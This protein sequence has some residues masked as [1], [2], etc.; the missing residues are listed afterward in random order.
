MKSRRLGFLAVTA[1]FSVGIA[2]FAGCGS[3]S[4][5]A[6]DDSND[7]GM[8]TDVTVSDSSPGSDSSSD[9]STRAFCATGKTWTDADGG[10]HP[11][12]APQ[13]FSSDMAGCPGQV[14]WPDR[15]SL[16]APS[17]RTCSAAEWVAKHG[18]ALPAYHF[19]TNDDLGYSGAYKPGYECFATS[20]TDVG[21]SGAQ[22]VSTC[23]TEADYPDGGVILDDGGN[24]IAADA[25]APMRVCYDDPDA[26]NPFG[27][28][29]FDSLGNEC[30]WTRCTYGL[31]PALIIE[32]GP[33]GAIDTADAS[34][35][36]FDSMGGCEDNRTAGTLCCCP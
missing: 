4:D 11:V 34:H 29:T 16:C 12:P 33:D 27:E 6:S 2:A 19:W 23:F 25:D 14:L 30:N 7:S 21:D 8:N 9:S 22:Y 1:I 3:S 26:A 20:A 5:G 15:T 18:T 35:P 28:G 31:G 24:E 13:V 10:V 36:N 17:C 32:A